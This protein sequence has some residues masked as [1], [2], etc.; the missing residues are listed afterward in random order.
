MELKNQLLVSGHAGTSYCISGLVQHSQALE[1]V[2]Q[3]NQ[4][5]GQQAHKCTRETRFEL[6]TSNLKIF[7]QLVFSVEL[8]K[9]NA[10]AITGCLALNIIWVCKSLFHIGW[11]F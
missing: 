3:R 2:E 9:K 10:L 8:F 1:I 7:I 11:Q 5:C 4:R 6:A